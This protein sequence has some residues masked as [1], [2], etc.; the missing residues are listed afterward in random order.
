[1]SVRVTLFDYKTSEAQLYLLYM[2]FFPPLHYTLHITVLSH[3][4]NLNAEQLPKHLR[5][6]Y[7]LLFKK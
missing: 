7:F 3:K 4:I 2:E 6:D 1:M 5:V